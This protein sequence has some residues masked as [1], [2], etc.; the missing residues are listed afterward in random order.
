MKDFDGH[1]L[2]LVAGTSLV[3]KSTKLKSGRT[4]RLIL[5]QTHLIEVNFSN[6]VDGS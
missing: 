4:G 3:R 6:L 1:N 2:S 5:F